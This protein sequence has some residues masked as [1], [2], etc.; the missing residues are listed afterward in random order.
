MNTI[1]N[2]FNKEN[3]TITQ[4]RD[5]GSKYNNDNRVK[6]KF[7]N[8]NRIILFTD[9]TGQDVPSSICIKFSLKDKITGCL[10]LLFSRVN[11]TSLSSINVSTYN[12]GH[13]VTLDKK[14]SEDKISLINSKEVVFK[15]TSKENIDERGYIKIKC[16]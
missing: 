3:C 7:I 10:D 6:I 8:E 15:L 4:Y 5:D 9:L 2:I 12:Q 11:G 14:I 1:T 13:K 16:A